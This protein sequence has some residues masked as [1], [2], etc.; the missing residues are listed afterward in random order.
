MSEATREKEQALPDE[1]TLMTRMRAKLAGEIATDTLDA[2][3]AAGTSAYGLLVEAEQERA[4]LETDDYWTVPEAKQTFF[5][6]SWNAFVLQSI[7]DAFIEADFAFDPGTAGF[8]PPI[9]AEQ[10]MRF[11]AEVEHWLVRA[12][13]ARTDDRYRLDLH[14]PAELP[15]WVEVEPCP[16]AHLH[17]MLTAERALREH[18]EIAVGDLR[19]R[20]PEKRRSAL[21]KI[22]SLLAAVQTTADYAD[23]LH[24]QLH[25]AKSASKGLHERIERSI[26]DALEKAFLVGQ[27]AAMPQLEE[28]APAGD[29][30]PARRLPG[31]GERGFDPWCLTDPQT[32]P[33]WQ[34]D[35]QAQ[36]AIDALWKNDPDPTRTLELKAAID[37]ALASG[38]VDYA[39][40]ARGRRLGNYY[41]CPWS[42]VYVAKRPVKI[43][44]K[45]LRPLQQFT[46]DVSAEEVTEGGDFKRELLLASFSPTDEIDYCD[47][48][49]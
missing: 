30:T 36:A 29:R 24:T 11:Y 34:R 26:K 19:R 40:D 42:A 23:Q 35:R 2:Y 13:Q 41:C 39:T 16:M 5:L 48:N 44:G 31:P 21:A 25:G 18:A 15:E 38:D 3:R 43:G 10:A 46:L 47:P 14:V 7:A 1:P 28:S 20:A 9:T 37:A 8:V 45:R 49:A 33:R 32:R 12:G 22:E 6:A 17:A 27:L 4:A